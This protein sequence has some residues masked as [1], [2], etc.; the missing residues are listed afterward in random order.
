MDPLI[1]EVA[2]NG[3]TP[4]S[5]NPNVP[6]SPDEI[7]A[8]TL[9]C[10]EAGASVIHSHIETFDLYGQAAADRYAEGYREILAQRPD[11]ILYATGVNAPTVE[12][13]C[14]HTELLAD[15][16]LTRMA[17]ID[18][19]STNFGV[20]DKDGLPKDQ[21]WIYAN[22]YSEIDYF[23]E[24]MRKKKLGPGISIYE[25]NFLRTVLVYERAGKL[26]QGAFVKFYMAGDYNF[27]DGTK[28]YQF[29]GLPATPTGVA[30]YLEMMKGSKLPWAVTVMGGDVTE[31]GLS[32]LAIEQGGHIR[33]GL[34]DYCGPRQPRNIELV[35]EVAAL[36]KKA[37]RPL[38]AAYE[39]A[40]ILN[41]PRKPA[42]S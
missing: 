4:K 10:L 20:A 19:G 14:L 26:P 25:P 29:W 30:A 24:M 16:G 11:A 13:R 6:L 18:P 1:I 2:I 42:K 21:G 31:T 5:R 41:L 27:M 40:E 9:E 17:F 12:E 7:A 36:A 32:Q 37:G 3:G 22:P 38:A 28:T 34:E 39:A 8:D 15:A 35:E 33:L 23:F